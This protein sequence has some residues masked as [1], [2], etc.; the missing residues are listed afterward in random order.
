MYPLNPILSFSKLIAISYILINSCPRVSLSLSRVALYSKYKPNSQ[1]EPVLR[2]KKS[3]SAS[4]WR[5]R[6]E[7]L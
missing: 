2:S 3:C 1:F 4:T 5:M 6:P 7:S